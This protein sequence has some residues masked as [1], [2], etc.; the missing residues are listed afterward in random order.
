MTIVWKE[1]N[2][3]VGLFMEI[4]VTEQNFEE[5]V[6]KSEL[7]VLVDFFATWCGPCQMMAPILA[8][9]A[10]QQEGKIKVCKCDIDQNMDLAKEYKIRSVPTLIAFSNGEVKTKSIGAISMQEMESMFS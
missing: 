2:R 4:I 3:K 7:P 1:A 6:L 10:Q 9:F 8:Q 5:E